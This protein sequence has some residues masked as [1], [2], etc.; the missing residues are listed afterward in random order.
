MTDELMELGRRAVAC[1]GWRWMPGMLTMHGERLVSVQEDAG[2]LQLAVCA[3][4]PNRGRLV[5]N[6]CETC[7]PDLSD[8]A[9]VGCLLRLVRG[10]WWCDGIHAT[11]REGGNEW[12][13]QRDPWRKERPISEAVGSD[14][15]AAALVAALEAA[16]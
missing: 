16:P 4:E 3:D 12:F 8:A 6:R 13:V 9:T 1:K 11:R 2:W 7:V 10:A 14:A 5:F 15:E